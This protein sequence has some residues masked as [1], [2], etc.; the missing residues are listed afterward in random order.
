MISFISIFFLVI[1]IYYIIY[2]F[3]YKKNKDKQTY[4]NIIVKNIVC[5]V[6]INDFFKIKDLSK[7]YEG[8]FNKELII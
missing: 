5:P 4:N 2:N 8:I 3:L 1:L 6:S 7:F